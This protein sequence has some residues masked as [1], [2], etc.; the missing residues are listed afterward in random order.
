MTSAKSKGIV[1][2]ICSFFIFL[3]VYTALSK[4]LELNRFEAV[5][6]TSPLIGD[7]KAIVAWSLP[8]IELIVA[9]LL[10]FPKT[11]PI[12]LLF[13]FFLMTIFTLYVIYMILSIPNLV[14]SCGGIISSLT[15]KQH[16]LL[17]VFF[18]MLA[19]AG[20]LLKRKTKVFIRINRT[21]RTPV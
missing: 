6:G 4:F 20:M 18:M 16:L 1:Q 9:L 21:S 3:F 13:S 11:Q 17:N 8:S 7:K 12:G 10:L 14:C 19:L 15:W 5:L 2:L